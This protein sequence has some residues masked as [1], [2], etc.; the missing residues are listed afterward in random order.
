[1]IIKN[2]HDE[3]GFWAYHHS[4]S[5]GPKEHTSHDWRGCRPAPD[6]HG[7]WKTLVI[8]GLDSLLEISIHP[9]TSGRKKNHHKNA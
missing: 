3:T 2:K 5:P 8:S 7:T 6:L 4:P 1:M 9:N